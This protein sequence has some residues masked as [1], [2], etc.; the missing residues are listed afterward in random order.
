MSTQPLLQRTAAKRIALPVKVEPKVSFA[1][2]RT[3]LSWLH[4]TVVL[5][6]LAVGLLNFGDKVGQISAAMFS[7]VAV[8]VMVYALWTYHW[9]A[10]SIR[11]GGRGP[12]DDRIGPTVLCI[13]LLGAIIA[14]FV[15][16]FT[17]PDL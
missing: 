4:F 12:Y 9:R 16:R 7:V 5:G 6:G 17:S 14:N 3:F 2:E 8:A 13:A 15:L 1:N 10:N 11:T